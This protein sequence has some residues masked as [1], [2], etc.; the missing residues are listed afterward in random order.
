MELLLIS[1]YT[2]LC[3]AIFTVLRIPLNRWTVPT[4]SIGGVVL[5]F[6]LIQMPV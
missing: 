5:S 4:A 1:V 3:I 2:A 6:A